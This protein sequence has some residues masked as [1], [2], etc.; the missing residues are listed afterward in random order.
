[1]TDTWAVIPTKGR[2]E[3]IRSAIESLAGQVTGVFVVD[4]NDEPDH[5][6]RK[7]LDRRVYTLHHPGYPPNLSQLLN[8]GI[9]EVSATAFAHWERVWNVVLMND[10]VTVPPGWV[11]SLIEPMRK[12]GAA[13]AYTDR[14]GRNY[15]VMMTAPPAGQHEQSTCWACVVR[16]ELGIMWDEELKW[17]YGDNMFDL[18]CRRKGGVLAVPGVIPIHSHPSA[19]TFASAELSA[20]THLDRETFERKFA[21]MGW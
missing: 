12:T 11:E 1:M 10:D 21:T 6:L 4:N 7:M 2:P 3:L 9:D 5:E 17:W 14:M 8:F 15:P 16:G 13:L 19:Q 20:Q 18:E